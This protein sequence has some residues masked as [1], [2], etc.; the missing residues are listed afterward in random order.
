V[1]ERDGGESD[2]WPQGRAIIVRQVQAGDEREC[3]RQ[4]FSWT[5][6]IWKKDKGFSQ[7]CGNMLGEGE[8]AFQSLCS[9]TLI[10]QGLHHGEPRRKRALVGRDAKHEASP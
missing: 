2:V 6:E 9:S 10:D 4:I 1:E 5:P 7:A 8:T 3:V